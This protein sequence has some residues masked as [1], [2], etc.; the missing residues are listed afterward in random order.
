MSPEEL[1]LFQLFPQTWI[2]AVTTFSQLPRHK[3]LDIAS[4]VANPCQPIRDR[5][6]GATTLSGTTCI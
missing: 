5:W 6:L 1:V 2:M 4:R 3:N